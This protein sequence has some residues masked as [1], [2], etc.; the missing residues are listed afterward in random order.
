MGEE[1]EPSIVDYVQ[2]VEEEEE[3]KEKSDWNRKQK[4]PEKISE[5]LTAEQEL[6]L[7]NIRKIV[8]SYDYDESILKWRKKKL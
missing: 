4:G 1:S 7:E 5:P 6:E 8:E 2:E 3:K